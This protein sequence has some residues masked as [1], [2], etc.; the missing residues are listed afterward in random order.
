MIY[1]TPILMFWK[2]VMSFDCKQDYFEKPY[3]TTLCDIYGYIAI[4]I[5]HV[6]WCIRTRIA[7]TRVFQTPNTLVKELVYINGITFLI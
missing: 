4:D 1:V 2:V 6:S 3:Q 7:N 5:H